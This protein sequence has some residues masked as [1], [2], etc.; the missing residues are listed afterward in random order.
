MAD[1]NSSLPVRTQNNGD[2]VAQLSDGITPSQKLAISGSGSA[3]VAGEGVAG[4]P[5]G[6]VLSI[7]GVS[8][9]TAVPVSGTVSVL[10]PAEGPTGSLPPS[11]AIYIGALAASS[12]PTL[13]SGDMYSLSLTTSGAVRVDGSATTQPVSGTITANQG[14]S[15][16][17]ENLT[18]VGGSA[19]ALGQTTMSAS[20]PVA[21]ASNQTA[22]PSNITQIA[23]SAPSA[24]NSLAVQISTGSAY[25]SSSNPLPVV[26]DP[27][28]AGTS[29]LDYKDA[30]SIA[31]GSSDN[32][33]YTVT[34]GKTLH[35]Q[36]IESSASGKAKMQL[37]VETGVA[38]GTFTTKVVQFNSTAAPNMT[39]RL[40]AEILVPAGVRVRV[41]MSNNDLLAQDL[42]SSIIGFEI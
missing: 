33:D 2:I 40:Q 6:G 21:I 26:I 14:T 28:G 5:T 42:Y 29:V 36:Q 10:D 11:Q 37:L 9:G 18:Q 16:W 38:S 12:A 15:P 7:Q 24:S 34:V 25:V 17:V 13:I 19:I 31:S 3:Q 27:Q 35:L 22:L 30:S 20:L 23:G 4:T 8:G 1:F 41:I 32:H 39:L